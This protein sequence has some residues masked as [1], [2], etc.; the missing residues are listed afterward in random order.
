MEE[1]FIPQ[2]SVH[3][4]KTR[5]CSRGAFAIPKVKGFGSKSFCSLGCSLWNSLPA[6]ISSIER[7]PSFKIAVKKYLMDSL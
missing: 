3:S 2:D 5:S 4:H 7:L 1:S 6:D